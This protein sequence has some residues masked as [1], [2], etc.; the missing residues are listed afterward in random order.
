[1]ARERTIERR[2]KQRIEDHG[3]ACEKHVGAMRGDPD[4]L[5]SFPNGYHC[6]AETKWE[7]GVKPE[8]HQLRR[9]GF[10]RRRGLDVWVIGCNEHIEQLIDFA[11]LQPPRLSVRSWLVFGGP[12]KGDVGG[13]PW[14]GKNG[15]EPFGPG[16][17]QI[18]G[19]KLLP[20]AGARTEARRGRRMGRGER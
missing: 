4:R 9:H 12:Y 6:L 16:H 19:F 10:W 2:L 17:A 15:D 7:E 11:S 20:G 18:S 13:G 3:G 14:P 5:C 8:D 1:M